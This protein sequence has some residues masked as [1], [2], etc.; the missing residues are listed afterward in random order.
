MREGFITAVSGVSGS[1]KMTLVEKTAEHLGAIALLFDSYASTSEYPR[2]LAKWLQDGADFNAWKTPQLAQDV[3][4]LK[5]GQNIVSPV[6]GESISPNGI[7]L[8][9]DPIGRA[10][11]EMI[12]LIDFVVWLDIPLEVALARR[13]L[14]HVNKYCRRIAEKRSDELTK[15]ELID[16]FTESMNKFLHNYLDM[17]RGLYIALQEQ[18]KPHCDL[19]LDGCLPADELALQFAEVIKEKR[20]KVR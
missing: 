19:I 11:R 4:A 10:R 6:T 8:I 17:H 9:E 1:G 3:R 15:E 18:V 20:E 14:R 7:V 12:D 5:R 2:D 16:Y 13:L